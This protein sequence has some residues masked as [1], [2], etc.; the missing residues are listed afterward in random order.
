MIFVCVGSRDYQFNRLIKKLDEL[1]ENG[2]LKEEVFAQI[3]SSDYIPK[4]FKYERFLDTDVFNKYVDKCRILITHGGTGSI[5]GALKKGKY[6]I[7]VPRLAKYG[8]HIDDHQKQIIGV[9][10]EKKYIKSV[11]EMS[12][13]LD[14]IKS[15]DNPKDI[16]PYNRESHVIE[17]LDSYIME[18]WK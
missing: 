18:N 9:C 2:D 1:V 12:E 6:V 17:I 5:I 8:E 3:G 14:A 15:F 4:N 16:V 7:G 13:L 10:T 11:L